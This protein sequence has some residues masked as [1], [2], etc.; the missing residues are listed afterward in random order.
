LPEPLLR[1]LSLLLSVQALVPELLLT[2]QV[3]LPQL[4]VQAQLLLDLSELEQLAVET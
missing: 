2:H 3:E 4:E 1:L